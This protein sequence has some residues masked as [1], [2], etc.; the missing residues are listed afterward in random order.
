MEI[1]LPRDCILM[2]Y[3][4]EQSMPTQAPDDP[5][6]VL[7]VDDQTIV[8]ES[9]RALLREHPEIE[10][11]TVR[12]PTKAINKANS[13]HPTVILQDLN[14]P[15]VDGLTLIRFFRA[16]PTTTQVPLIVLSSQEEPK[17]KASAFALGANDYLI[18]LPDAVELVARIKHH[19]RA[20]NN[21][22]QRQ[23]AERELAAAKKAAEEAS[24][25][26]SASWL[27]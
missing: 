6:V 10:L 8:H 9:V 16:N 23:R 11:H 5:I 17:I 19:S 24:R 26:K 7:L 3:S 13:V 27:P 18:K 15:Q 2:T 21:S 20:Y 22:R 4:A 25:S 14:M 12:D 1:G